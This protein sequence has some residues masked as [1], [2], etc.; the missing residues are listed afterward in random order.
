MDIKAL[1]PEYP[2]QQQLGIEAGPIVLVNIFTVDPADQDALIEAWR[3][4]AL[5]MKKQPGYISTQLHKAIGE[6]S[7]YL[8]YAVWDLWPT[9][10]RLLHTPSSRMRLAIIRQARLRLRIFLKRLPFQTAALPD[11]HIKRPPSVF[12]RHAQTRCLRIV[13]GGFQPVFSFRT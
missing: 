6:S 9:S 8:N 5:W 1:D 7:M 10:A 3:N 11:K 2:I 13:P 4:D 12:E